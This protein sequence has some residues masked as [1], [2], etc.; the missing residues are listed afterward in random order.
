MPLDTVCEEI[1]YAFFG[2]DIRRGQG[3]PKRMGME[4]MKAEMNNL[5]WSNDVIFDM[6]KWMERL[7]NLNINPLKATEWEEEK[8]IYFV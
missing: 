2:D 6:M 3:R 1:W 7:H 4:V 5:L 8:L